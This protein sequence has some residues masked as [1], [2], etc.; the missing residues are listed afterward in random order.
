MVITR[1][2]KLLSALVF[3]FCFISISY[4][5]DIFISFKKITSNP[6]TDYFPAWSPDGKYLAFSRRNSES[7]IWII[8]SNGGEEK[9]LTNVHSGHPDWSPDGSYIVFDNYKNRLFQIIT[10]KG[11]LPVNII[12]GDIPAAD[13]Y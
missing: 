13:T 7:R 10:V 2:I 4:S 1:S 9:Q 6:A 12:P 8:P 3:L 5:Q 11:G